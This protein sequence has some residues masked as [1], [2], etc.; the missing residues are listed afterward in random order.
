MKFM[1]ALLCHSVNGADFLQCFFFFFNT[2]ISLS[3][4]YLLYLQL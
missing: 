3:A 2:I 1:W 4:W